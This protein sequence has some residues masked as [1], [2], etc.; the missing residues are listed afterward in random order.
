MDRIMFERSLVRHAGGVHLLAAPRTFA[1]VRHVTGDGVRQALN[2]S[3]A[4]FP[5][6]VADLDHSFRE[7]QLQV[8]RQAD[9]I[10]LVLRLDFNALRHVQ[11]S[12]DYLRDL[13]L[14]QERVRLVVNRYGQP[15]EVPYAKAEEALG[16]KI[17]HYVPDDP[18]TVNVSNNN[19]APA[20][21]EYPRARVSRSV[22]R[23]AASVNGRPAKY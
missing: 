12:V 19:G 9:M 17:F 22:V 15:K 23:L 13:G 3:R 20:V 7:E 8:L 5:Y 11:R 16:L 2:L 4:L 14:S 18:K 6:V 21:L 1:D 10:L